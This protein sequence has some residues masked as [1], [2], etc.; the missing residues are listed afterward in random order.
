MTPAQALAAELRAEADRAM[1]DAEAVAGFW[2]DEAAEHRGQAAAKRDAAARLDALGDGWRGI[3]S[4]PRDGSWIL[5]Y[6]SDHKN[7]YLHAQFR[8]GAWWGQLT[9]SGRAVVWHDPRYWMPLPEP[10]K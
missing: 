6:D 10:P 8:R 4:A 3:E 5:L 1:A 2:R 9:Q 7:P